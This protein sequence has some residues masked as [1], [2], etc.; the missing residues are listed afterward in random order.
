MF[1]KRT[2]PR[3]IVPSSRSITRSTLKP[4]R[5]IERPNT[6]SVGD[7]QSAL[8]AKLF[9]KNTDVGGFPAALRNVF[10]TSTDHANLVNLTADVDST[11]IDVCFDVGRNVTVHFRT[12]PP[13]T[14]Q[15]KTIDATIIGSLTESMTVAD[16]VFAA[17][18]R[19]GIE[20]TLHRVS[21][22][23]D[24]DGTISGLTWR[25]GRE[26]SF[27]DVL[28]DELKGYLA[29]GK[30]ILFFGRPGA[31]K[32]TTLRGAAT[33]LGDC[34]P[35]RTIVVDATGE[36]GGCGSEPIGIGTNTRRMCVA[37]GKSHGDAMMAAIRNHTPQALIVD[38]IMTRSEA[39]LVQTCRARGI[40]LVATCHASGLADVVENP[41]FADLMGGNQNAAVSDASA[42]QRGSKFVRARKHA[43]V[44]DGAYDV[45]TK[46]LYPN[47]SQFVD[48][49]FEYF[50]N[51]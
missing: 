39:A 26:V 27:H 12:G 5:S 18:G 25:I 35:R 16:D 4:C 9:G 33:Y 1:A 46:T 47:L 20:G 11:V 10:D 21:A 23:N 8:I 50:Y 14:M 44:F 51:V 19:M 49:Y 22:L 13:L 31:G 24:F 48:E 6:S 34:A 36:L 28:T 43:P 30:S 29:L 7:V 32:T 38:E 41:V 40:Q 42:T 37:P 2:C 17:T 3:T 15:S 45:E